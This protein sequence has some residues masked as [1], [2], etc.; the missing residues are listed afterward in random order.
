MMTMMNE[1]SVSE[2]VGFILILSLVVTSIGIV[3]LYGYPLLLKEQ[4]ATD[5]KNMEQTMIVL[6]NDIKS[7]CYRNVPYTEMM[8][9]AGGGTLSVLDSGDT[10]Q[11][12]NIS[13]NGNGGGAY[14]SFNPGE[15][16]YRSDT[17]N[18]IITLENGAVH[19]RLEFSDAAG[20]SM[21]AEPRWFYDSTTRTFV[22]YLMEL[23]ANSP[24]GASGMCVIRMHVDSQTQTI[25]DDAGTVQ[26][27]YQYCGTDDYS[28]AWRNYLTGSVGM[29][30]TA[31]NTYTKTGVSKLVIKHYRITVDDL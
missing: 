26:V 7:L 8:L 9:Q 19:E 1:N 4:G 12:F 18:T 2:T 28:V 6:Q 14:S 10:P 16:R 24:M 13:W 21:L 22:I 30:K 17:E 25:I 3:T 23:Q 31:A 5:V 20:S 11:Y 27:K 15:L 29:T